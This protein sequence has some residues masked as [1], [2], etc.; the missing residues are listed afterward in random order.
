MLFLD[1][2]GSTAAQRVLYDMNELPPYEDYA[3][4]IPVLMKSIIYGQSIQQT[5]GKWRNVFK[6]LCRCVAYTHMVDALPDAGNVTVEQYTDALQTNEGGAL[7]KSQEVSLIKT[8]SLM[9]NKFEA[10]LAGVYILNETNKLFSKLNDYRVDDVTE[11]ENERLITIL[12]H[13]ASTCTYNKHRDDRLWEYQKL[14]IKPTLHASLGGFHVNETLGN[15]CTKEYLLDHSDHY[16]MPSA[17]Q[18]INNIVFDELKMIDMCVV[19][20]IMAEMLDGCDVRAYINGDVLKAHVNINKMFTF[21]QSLTNVSPSAQCKSTT[22]RPSSKRK[23]TNS[24][25][26]S[27]DDN[28]DDNTNDDA[29]SAEYEI[30]ITADNI[31]DEIYRQQVKDMMVAKNIYSAA[32]EELNIKNDDPSIVIFSKYCDRPDHF[33]IYNGKS[34]GIVGGV[35]K[36]PICSTIKEWAKNTSNASE[37][38]TA[39]SDPS[40]LKG[41]SIYK[42]ILR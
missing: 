33:C 38:Y 31:A 25:S 6:M 15:N 37:L 24:I 18:L 3:T 28:G 21:H 14:L 5:V 27:D 1:I 4:A 30:D 10:D 17:T 41:S 26:D 20:Y 34:L 11:D 36:Y 16:I 19:T 29:T 35:H 42:T 7:T 12:R 9:N 39:I 40:K 23:R 13:M 22:D 8:L 2:L 32:T